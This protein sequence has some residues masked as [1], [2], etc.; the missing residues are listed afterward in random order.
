MGGHAFFVMEA[1]KS[2][3]LGQVPLSCEPLLIQ[4]AG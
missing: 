4:A 1:C 2:G 3:V